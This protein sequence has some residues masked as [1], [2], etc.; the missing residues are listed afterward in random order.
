MSTWKIVGVEGNQDLRTVVA[1]VR[2]HRLVLKSLRMRSLR[3]RDR[4]GRWEVYEEDKD[5]LQMFGGYLSPRD[6]EALDRRLGKMGQQNP[7][8]PKA[9][10][11][12]REAWSLH[13]SRVQTSGVEDER[14]KARRR[15]ELAEAGAVC[16]AELAKA[17]LGCKSRRADVRD[18]ARTDLARGAARR[19][20]LRRS[21]AFE[22]GRAAPRTWE[23][24]YSRSESDSL[25]EHNIPPELMSTWRAERKRFDYGAPPDARAVAFLEWYG[26]H[27]E[28]VDAERYAALEM[29]PTAYKRAERSYYAEHGAEVPF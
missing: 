3:E 29:S 8:A 13:K 20:E 24:A 10:E 14:T 6:G 2:R 7:K 26:E 21:Y 4:W 5:G 9:R 19:A 28:E 12:K 27:Q 23:R 25:A 17:R 16:A 18:R 15:T 22:M 1:K 11:Q